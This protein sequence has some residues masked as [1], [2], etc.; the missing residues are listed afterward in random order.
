MGRGPGRPGI[1]GS[2]AHERLRA[3][4]DP[5]LGCKPVPLWLRLW[6]AFIVI[7]VT[8]IFA[9]AIWLGV[10]LLQAGPEGVGAELGRAYKAFRDAAR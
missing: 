10:S 9:G 3:R 8:A 2:S 1:H 5:D 6:F 7:M 4:L